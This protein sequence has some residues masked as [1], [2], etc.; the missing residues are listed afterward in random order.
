MISHPV[1][2][3]LVNFA[4]TNPKRIAI[5]HGGNIITYRR[6]VGQL[7]SVADYL[8]AAG[9][10]HRTCAGLTLQNE[11]EHLKV[12]LALLVLGADQITLPSYET[13]LQRQDIATRARID[14]VI[15]TSQDDELP[16]HRF[17]VWHPSQ[18]KESRAFDTNS[19]GNQQGRIFFK[20]S[21]TTGRPNIIPL[22]EAQLCLQAMRHKEYRSENLLRFAS[23]EYNNSKRHRLYSLCNGGQNTF[24]STQASNDMDFIIDN[25]VTCLD[26]S[27]IHAYDL[28][29]KPL[30]SRLSAIKIRTGGS[31]VPSD[32]RNKLLTNVSPRLYVRYAASECGGIAM[33]H[34]DQHNIP[35]CAGTIL[36]GVSVEIVDHHDRVLAPNNIGEIRVKAPGMA[37]G[38]L[39][40]P[41]QTERRFKK[42][43]FYPGDFGYIA[44]TGCLFVKGRKD[45]MINMNGINI[46]PS[47]IEETIEK[48]PAIKLAAAVGLDSPVHGQIPVAAVEL[49]HN[50]RTSPKEIQSFAKNILGIKAPRKIMIL[51]SLPKNSQGKL[52]KSELKAIFIDGVKAK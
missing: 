42:G 1:I 50:H 3:K 19:L 10:D 28:A 31:A 6:L 40:N 17:I 49:K 21:G 12:S 52:I 25:E 9:V 15:G 30:A 26:I 2:E 36:D 29:N 47:E 8:R 44:E 5:R 14:V 51:S 24:K 7:Q 45:E 39:D 4:R 46:F 18:G 34:P 43:F 37:D 32:L 22:S 48:H 38:Y 35:D 41:D 33:A 13:H 11:L 16:G 27:R 20:T 23:V